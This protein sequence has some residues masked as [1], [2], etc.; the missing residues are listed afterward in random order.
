MAKN[1]IKFLLVFLIIFAWIFSGWP[2]IFNPS[3]LFRT[4]FPPKIQEAQAATAGPSFPT[5]GVND[6]SIG[7]T[8]WTAP[9][10]V[11][12]SE[13][14]RATVTLVKNSGVS[15][16]IK[17][18]GFGF[19]IPADA[20]IDGITVE[21]E[22]SEGGTAAA[23]GIQDNAVR[24]V[25][26]G[27]IEATDR[28]N[29]TF[30][31]A[32]ASEAFVTYGGV[33]DLWGATWTATDINNANF[34]AAIS[35]KNV[36]V[37]GGGAN[38]DAQVDAVRITVTYTLPTY[39]QSAYRLFNNLDSTDVG[40]TLAAQDTAATLGSTGALFRLRMLLH[41]GANQLAVSGQTFKL[42]FAAQSGTCDTAFS[43][44]TYADITAATVIAY[45]DNLT[46][47]DGAT[48]TAN[49]NDP[50]H[51]A[52]ATSTQT[53]EELNNFTNSVAAIPSGQDGKWD[54]SLFDNGA[55]SSTAYCLRA[56]KSD[57]AVL[58]TYSV[59]PQIT[60]AAA[61]ATVSCSTN[62]TSTAFGTLTTSAVGTASSNAS[63]TMT[64]SGTTLGCTLYV[65]DNG[66]GANGGLWNSTSSY[67]IPSPNAAFSTTATLVAG[68]EGYGIQAATS[69]AGS[70]GTLKIN[71]IYLQ[72][73]DTV[74]GLT[75]S[76]LTLA[77]SSVDISNREIIVSHKAAV[78]INT[79]S[80]TYNDT[81]TYS[82]LSN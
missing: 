70:G 47:A 6:T 73:G 39:T 80:G 33:V 66:N 35:A 17:A 63:T 32:P 55:T 65:K 61:A 24:L 75:L 3:T 69:S 77:S 44:E 7:I 58:G 18:T 26:A 20:F 57:G 28:S 71:S 76:N 68:T 41:I 45:K 81:I 31:V 37:S 60:T 72:T 59:I 53:Y 50:T 46:P 1:F 82:C 64:C 42:Q 9:G 40:T 78:S 49:A 30:W 12:A 67:I 22:T 62:I 5:S 51:G 11:T 25:R 36:K 54:F 56:V 16:A 74:G 15:Q 8:A 4:G 2:Q 10:N 52:D 43:G 27:T 13:N 19:A 29:T 34:G 79:L 38:E 23:G 14:T 48:L 21:W